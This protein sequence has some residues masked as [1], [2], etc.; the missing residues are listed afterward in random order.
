[1][2]YIN[3]DSLKLDLIRWIAQLEDKKILEELL[4]IKEVQQN[5]ILEEPITP[6][7]SS[8]H[9]YLY[10]DVLAI[11]AQFPKDKL[12]TYADLQKYFPQNLK[13]KVEIL[14]HQ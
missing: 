13:V 4:H 7:L 3:P 9:T 11:A 14:N 5:K 6:Y 10:E 1:M 12:W 2:T 8:K